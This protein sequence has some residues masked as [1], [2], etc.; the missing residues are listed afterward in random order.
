MA[1]TE[2]L[3]E[4]LVIYQIGGAGDPESWRPG[5]K[6]LLDEARA[7][8]YLE[9]GL[10]RAIETTKP[11]IEIEPATIVHE[12]ESVEPADASS[13]TEPARKGKGD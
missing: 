8:L 5:S 4:Y 10:V 11:L 9:A 2:R 1:E 13:A 6:I 3:S 7:R 12:A